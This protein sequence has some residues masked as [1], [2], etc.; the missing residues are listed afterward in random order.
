MWVARS[1]TGATS[2]EECRE[3]AQLHVAAERHA[4]DELRA[5]EPGLSPEEKQAARIIAGEHRAHL[6]SAW[7]TPTDQ[8]TSQ[9]SPNL[10]ARR[11]RRRE[12]ESR[13]RDIEAAALSLELEQIRLLH[14]S[15]ELS[16]H[17]ARE[18][19]EEVYLLQMGL[20]AR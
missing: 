10:Q 3:L 7:V 9:G 12:A 14:D 6:A 5:M 4:I 8:E 15:G 18:L 16:T 13:A 17:A 19:R 20:E 11:A 2:E 1:T